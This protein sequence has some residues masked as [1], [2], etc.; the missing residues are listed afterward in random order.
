MKL[1]SIFAKSNDPSPNAILIKL[2]KAAL[3]CT[4]AFGLHATPAT[5]EDFPIEAQTQICAAKW[6]DD[7]SMQKYCIDKQRSAFAKLQPL[8]LTLNEDLSKSN[9]KCTSDWRDDFSM[10]LFCIK[11]KA[12][13]YENL[14][15]VLAGLPSDVAGVI[16]TKC[17][18]NWREDYAMQEFCSKKQADGWRAINE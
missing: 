15:S 2:T 1:A 5:A 3:F 17:A 14:P 10:Q 18:N 8:I 9:D 7:F 4:L 11:K 6:S 12:K 16:R 13:S